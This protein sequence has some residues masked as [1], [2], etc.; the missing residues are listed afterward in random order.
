MSVQTRICCIYITLVS[1]STF[2]LIGAD[3][4]GVNLKLIESTSREPILSEETVWGVS[5]PSIDIVV[6]PETPEVGTALSDPEESFYRDLL[7]IIRYG[8][9]NKVSVE[10][11]QTEIQSRRHASVIPMEEIGIYVMQVVLEGP[12]QP[13]ASPQALLNYIKAVITHMVRVFETHINEDDQQVSL[14]NE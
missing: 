5:R 4:I 10:D 1:E 11:I 9:A 2:L 12:A 14:I 3:N 6:R 13:V 8:Y 7:E